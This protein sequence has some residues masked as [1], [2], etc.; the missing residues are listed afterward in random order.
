MKQKLTTLEDA[1]RLIKNGDTVAVGGILNNRVPVAIVHQII[2]SGIKDLEILGL[3]QPFAYDL[4]LGAGCA[5][6]IEGAFFGLASPNKGFIHMPHIRRAA[7]SGSG[8]VKENIG[9]CIILSFEFGSQGVPFIPLKSLTGTEIVKA[10]PDLYKEVVSP[11]TGEK[12]IAFPAYNPDVAI[13]HAQRSD[14]FGNVQILDDPS[15]GLDRKIAFA[16]AKVIVTVEEIVSTSEIKGKVSI[17]YVSVDAVVKVPWGAHPS[18]CYKYYEADYSHL[19][20]YSIKAKDPD[21]FRNYLA[22]YIYKVDR[23]TYLERV[24]GARTLTRIS[25]GSEQR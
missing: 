10:R 12:L 20:E 2:R 3:E 17:P 5:R 19:D 6:S 18:T 21:W 9:D 16:S 24:G 25:W 7:E 13:I 23:E 4:L 15:P 14:E 1:V 8:A 22:R 11:F